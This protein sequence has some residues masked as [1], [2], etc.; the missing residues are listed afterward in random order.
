MKD[1]ELSSVTSLL[2]A[3]ASKRCIDIEKLLVDI[4]LIH[5]G[6]CTTMFPAQD[7]PKTKTVT[8]DS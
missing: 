8:E 3:L 2:L 6:F 7:E 4:P 1:N 5:H